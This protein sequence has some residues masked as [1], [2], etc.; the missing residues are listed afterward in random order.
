MS[1]CPE[2]E[3]FGILG[4]EEIALAIWPWFELIRDL[5]ILLK[6]YTFEFV[7]GLSFFPRE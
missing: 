3:E 6:T 2:G 4:H 1:L 7:S 5:L